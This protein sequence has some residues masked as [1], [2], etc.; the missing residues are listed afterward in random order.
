[1]S[2]R[3]T[4]V[5]PDLLVWARDRVG[6]S[7]AEAAHRL[8]KAGTDILAW[9]AGEAFPT[10]NQL[11]TLAAKVYHRPLAMFFLPSPPDE[12]PPGSEFRTLPSGVT[13]GFSPDTRFALREAEA[14]QISLSELTGG[15]NPAEQPIWREVSGRVGEARALAA[16]VRSFLGIS[17]QDQTRFGTSRDAANAWRDAIEKAGVFVL[18]R[19]LQE[20]EISGFCLDD[21]EFPIIVVNNSTSFTRQIFT[22]FHELAHILFDVSSITRLDMSFVNQMT[23]SARR[24]EVS[25]NEFAAEFLLPEDHFPWIEFRE[26][27]FDQAIQRTARRFWVSREVVLRR[28]LDA[29]RVTPEDYSAQVQVWFD[30]FQ[31]SRGEG[32][33]GNYYNT[34]AAYLGQNFL[35]LAFG[36][37]YSGRIGMPELVEHLGIKAKNMSRLEETA[38]ARS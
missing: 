4:S 34:V 13:N 7:P 6:M 9:E 18:K 5:N 15:Q 37:Y 11:E 28:L 24:I 35:E 2:T 38:L 10:Y 25:C 8:G 31:A 23:Q 30:E 17:L 29:E 33:G 36:Q 32:S 12:P 3:A 27:P 20:R 22:M 19:S 1:M 21:D 26:P 16:R 14:F